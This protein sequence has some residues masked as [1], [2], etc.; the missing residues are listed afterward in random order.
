MGRNSPPNINDIVN[1]YEHL[2]D[3]QKTKL[4]QLLNDYEDLFDGTLG[5]WKLLQSLWS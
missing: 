4:K 5:D 2:E 1:G 3:D